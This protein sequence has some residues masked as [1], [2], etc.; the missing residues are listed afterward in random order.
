MNAKADVIADVVVNSLQNLSLDEEKTNWHALKTLLSSK[1][2]M[3]YKNWTKTSDFADDLRDIIGDPNDEDSEFRHLFER[4]LRDGN[5][6]NAEAYSKAKRNDALDQRPWVVLVMGLNG[7]RKS[8]SLQ[9]PWFPLLLMEALGHKTMN[10]IGQ[11]ADMLPV[12]GNSFFRQLDYMI[13]T[14]ANEEFKALYER[15]LSAS[16]YSTLKDKIFKRYR[17]VAEALGVLLL[18]RAKANNMNILIETSGRDIAS[19]EYVDH[20]FNNSSYRKLVVHFTI[21]D[22]VHAERSV[23]SR[24]ASEMQAG[25]AASQLKS[26]TVLEE[27]EKIRAIVSVNAGGPYGSEVLR[28]VQA[29]SDKVWTQICGQDMFVDINKMQELGSTISS[30]M[31]LRAAVRIVGSEDPASWSA[32]AILPDGSLSHNEYFFGRRE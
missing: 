31:W 14:L 19:F 23:D 26:S 3:D 30:K 2:L 7:I 17:T 29:E 32:R 10:E 25:R 4:V 21:D 11:E 24:M 13:A 18:R 12:G 15:D 22:I 8:T 20:F 16:E 28:Q 1:T 9:Q 27:Y 6:F 5:W